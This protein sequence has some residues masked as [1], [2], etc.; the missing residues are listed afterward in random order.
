MKAIT[1]SEVTHT[2]GKHCIFLQERRVK[3]ST[4]PAKGGLRSCLVYLLFNLDDG[5]NTSPR[6]ASGLHL[7]AGSYIPEAR[8]LHN[9]HCL[10]L[11]STISINLF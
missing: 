2:R 6:H 9:Y 5:G 4:K 10:N 1:I 3:P 7:S 11:K 8:C